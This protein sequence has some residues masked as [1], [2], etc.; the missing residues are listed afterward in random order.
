MFT[1]CMI[2]GGKGVSV[3]PPCRTPPY[4]VRHRYTDALRTSQGGASVCQVLTGG[5]ANDLEG[6]GFYIKPTIL[7]GTNG[8]RLAVSNHFPSVQTNCIY[9]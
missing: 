2:Q 5:S 6:G 1:E 4:K 3:S 9:S 8:G 7:G